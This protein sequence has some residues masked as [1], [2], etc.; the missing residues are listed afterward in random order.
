MYYIRLK[1]RKENDTKTQFYTSVPDM[2]IASPISASRKAGASFVP[3]PV[4]ATTSCC[5]FRCCTSI[6][7]SQGLNLAKT[8]QTRSKQVDKLKH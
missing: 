6:N 1:T 3:S 5:S 8:C 4:T 7:L 2:P